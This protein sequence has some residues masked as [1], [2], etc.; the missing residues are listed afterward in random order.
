MCT[1]VVY[2]FVVIWQL[3][4]SKAYMYMAYVT[5]QCKAEDI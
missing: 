1:E 5:C 3:H 2:M 4:G